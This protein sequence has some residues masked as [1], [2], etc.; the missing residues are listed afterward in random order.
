MYRC[1]S[2]GYVMNTITK[3]RN[4]VC[5]ESFNG[6]PVQQ[7]SS[8][9]IP[10]PFLIPPMN[11]NGEGVL[12]NSSY[13]PNVYVTPNV[14]RPNQRPASMPP[15]F[16]QQPPVPQQWPQQDLWYHQELQRQAEAQRHQQ[17]SL[18]EFQRTTQ[19][20][21]LSIQKASEQN[22]EN[23]TRMFNMLMDQ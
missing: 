21:M 11:P 5:R 2:C 18:Q 16:H 4:H 7:E 12:P 6:A 17:E 3:T 1:K 10:S 14:I 13:T 8:S 20:S 15:G 23:M 19:Q 9:P 22:M